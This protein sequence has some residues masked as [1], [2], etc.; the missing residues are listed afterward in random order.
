MAQISGKFRI[1]ETN[2]KGRSVTFDG[3]K[4]N[5]KNRLDTED[6]E[7][8]ES[9]G[10]DTAEVL[11]EQGINGAVRFLG[12]QFKVENEKGFG[13]TVDIFEIVSTVN[14]G[15]RKVTR[16]KHVMFD[17]LTGLLRR[18][19]YT[20]FTKGDSVRIQTIYGKYEEVEGN[21]LPME[22]YRIEK[23]QEIFKYTRSSA[24]IK[25]AQHIENKF[26]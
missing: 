13:E 12:A 11:L 26:D 24:L 10:Y 17:S 5:S 2:G 19:S 7:L 9:L 25:Q 22:I 8:I 18:V 15:E 20:D 1:T 6:L 16:V 3:E 4:I 14:L 21:Q 23:G